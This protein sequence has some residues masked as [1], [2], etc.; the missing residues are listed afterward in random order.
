MRARCELG[1]VQITLAVAILIV[2]SQ[3]VRGLDL[4]G[5]LGPV[6]ASTEQPIAESAQPP[7]I[8]LILADDL[9]F[10]DIAPYGSEIRTPALSALAEQG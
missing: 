9:G 8:V 7:N 4:S 5:R 2:L 1:V 3:P 6:Q 10:S